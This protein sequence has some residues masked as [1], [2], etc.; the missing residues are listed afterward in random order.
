MKPS[1]SQTTLSLERAAALLDDK[2]EMLLEYLSIEIADGQLRAL[3]QLVDGYVPPL[4]GLPAFVR[5]LVEL[6]DPEGTVVVNGGEEAWD[7]L[8]VSGRTLRSFGLEVE[9]D[10]RASDLELGA[11]GTRFTLHVSGQERAVTSPLLGRYNVENALAAL[12]QLSAPDARVIRDGHR[13]V[14]PASDLVPGDVVVLEAGAVVP[15]DVRLLQGTGLQADESMLTG[16]S[17]PVEKDADSQL[18]AD[19]PVTARSN[20]LYRS[21]LVTRGRG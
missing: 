4:N 16:E 18:A 17:Q 1:H 15:A 9:A 3:P 7:S 19:A 8:D 21:T 5:R 11:G 13:A 12:R 6:V 10:V 14:L 2:A 20:L